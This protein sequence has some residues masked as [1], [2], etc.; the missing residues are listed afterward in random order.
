MMTKSKILL[1][2]LCTSGALYISAEDIKDGA[3][4][5]EGTVYDYQS[6]TPDSEV[7]RWEAGLVK[8]KWTGDPPCAALQEAPTRYCQGT[9]RAARGAARVQHVALRNSRSQ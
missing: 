7:R 8:K 6:P 1:L 9:A 5:V 2:F 3:P 4:S